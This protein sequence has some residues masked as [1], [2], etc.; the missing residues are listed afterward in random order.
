AKQI[1]LAVEVK[2]ELISKYPSQE[3]RVHQLVDLLMRK[4]DN[5]RIY[6]LSDY[7]M[8]LYLIAKEFNEFEKLIPPIEVVEELLK[9]GD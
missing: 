1:A 5:L 6:T 2:R 8:T 7:L 3:G 9:E 4:I